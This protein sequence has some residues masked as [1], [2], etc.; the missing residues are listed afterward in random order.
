MTKIRKEIISTDG[1]LKF[2]VGV[3]IKDPSSQTK[4]KAYTNDLMQELRETHYVGK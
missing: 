4:R 1:N 2:I 3:R